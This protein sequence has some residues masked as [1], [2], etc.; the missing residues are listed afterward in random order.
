MVY[1]TEF[2]QYYPQKSLYLL[3]IETSFFLF[4]LS[5]SSTHQ[6]RLSVMSVFLT[7]HKDDRSSYQAG[8]GNCS[9][10]LILRPSKKLESHN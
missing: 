1:H 10:S 6:F 8:F 7:C 2:T 4:C 5:H 3:K 9:S